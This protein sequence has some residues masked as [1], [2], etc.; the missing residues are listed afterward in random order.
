MTLFMRVGVAQIELLYYEIKLFYNFG[1]MMMDPSTQQILVKLI[2]SMGIGLLIGGDR[3]YRNKSAGLRTIMLIC[4]GSTLFT[5]ISFAMA[6]EGE[7]ARV[8]SNIVT[9]IG[10]LGAGA[11]MRDGLS[12]SGLTT[13]STIWAAAALGM[14]VGAGEFEM[15][16]VATVLVLVVLTIFSRLQRL[17]ERLHKTM[18]LRIFYHVNNNGVGDVEEKMRQLNI[19]FERKKE[20]QKND[21]AIYQYDIAGREKNLDK[22]ISH[23]TTDNKRVKG[24]EY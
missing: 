6:D 5:I 20:S 7:G 4:L 15:A 10:F 23:L 18:E 2:L 14:A 9:G 13:A 24:F 19:T 16:I 3:E 12:I 22:L 17:F 1:G 21:E 11:I 8:T